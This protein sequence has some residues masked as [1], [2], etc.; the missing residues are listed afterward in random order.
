MLEIEHQEE[1]MQLAVHC[2]IEFFEW[3]V[4]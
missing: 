1:E 4:E 3:R 2:M